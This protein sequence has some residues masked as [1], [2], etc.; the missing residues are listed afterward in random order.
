MERTPYLMGA[1]EN[2]ELGPG[3]ALA[4]L[5]YFEWSGVYICIW[6]GALKTVDD[7]LA[8]AVINKDC[9]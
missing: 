9:S 6:V 3:F 7:K 1:P 8:N 2:L 4:H 5:A